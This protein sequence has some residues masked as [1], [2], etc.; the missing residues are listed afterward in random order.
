MKCGV[1]RPYFCKRYSAIAQ[2]ICCH[3]FSCDH[4]IRFSMVFYRHMILPETSTKRNEKRPSIKRIQDTIVP[5]HRLATGQAAT[6]QY[7]VQLISIQN[8]WSRGKRIGKVPFCVVIGSFGVFYQPSLS[9]IVPFSYQRSEETGT[10]LLT[11]RVWLTI[12]VVKHAERLN[13]IIHLLRLVAG[14]CSI[15][16]V[17]NSH[18][19]LTSVKPI[20]IYIYCGNEE[21]TLES[22]GRNCKLRSW[23]LELRGPP[24]TLSFLVE[25]QDP[26]RSGF[27]L[28]LFLV[29]FIICWCR[30]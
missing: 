2:E 25:Q 6:S 4:T 30:C 16:Y 11:R 18:Y 19:V 3:L 10:C 26:L 13:F 9:L 5:I 12:Y 15:R 14:I 23:P 17:H 27:T 8:L 29:I 7:L 1:R 24:W 21:V 22:L 28:C 20:Y